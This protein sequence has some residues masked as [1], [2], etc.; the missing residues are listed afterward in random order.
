MP[1]G[2]PARDLVF[3]LHNRGDTRRLGQLLAACLQPGDCLLLEGP[4]H[5]GAALAI[6]GRLYSVERIMFEHRLEGVE[7]W[8][9]SP[10]AR[11]YLRLVLRGGDGFI[12]ALAYVERRNQRAYL[13]AIAD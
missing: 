7:W 12:E 8:S 9:R 13:Q 1:E 6:S 11:D 10:V 5:V 2:E 3:S 4:L